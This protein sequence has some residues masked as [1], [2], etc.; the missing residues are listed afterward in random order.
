VVHLYRSWRLL[1]TFPEPDLAVVIDVGEHLAHDPHRDV[2]THLYEILNLH[3]TDEPR[4]KPAWLRR[5]HPPIAAHLADD[6]TTAYRALSS[7]R[8]ET[9]WFYSGDPW[10]RARHWRA[11]RLRRRW[12]PVVARSVAS[13]GPVGLLSARRGAED[14]AATGT[15]Q[16]SGQLDTA[17]LTGGHR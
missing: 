3:P 10:C 9:R 13:A 14:H 6:L 16:W 15:R 1:I 8:S 4:T 2:Y 5:H 11:C 17:L 7:E 12:A